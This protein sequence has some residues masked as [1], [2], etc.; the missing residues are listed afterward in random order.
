MA[1]S[2]A[3]IRNATVDELD[4]IGPLWT[5]L[6]EHQTRNGMNVAVPGN[7]FTLWRDG[8]RPM[9]GRFV[10]VWIAEDQGQAVG[11]LCGRIR[12]LPPYFG[13][14]NVGFISDV[15]VS[16]SSR[17][18][19]IGRRLMATSVDWFRD[20]GIRRIE[21]Q[22]IAGNPEARALYHRLGWVDELTQMVRTLGD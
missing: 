19:G 16:E 14:G 6:Y 17:S 22:V 2:S 20:R 10:S 1:D 7:G 13:G 8:I 3:H 5:S 4:R 11:F 12:V 9:L 18:G 21:L 15:F